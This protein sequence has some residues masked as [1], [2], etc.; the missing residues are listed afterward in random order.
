M[1]SYQKAFIR[2]LGGDEE[3]P[4]TEHMEKLEQWAQA[5]KEIKGQ[6]L[7]PD[8]TA[9]GLK[10][11]LYLKTGIEYPIPKC[12]DKSRILAYY[13]I[14][15]YNIEFCEKKFSSEQDIVL[16]SQLRGLWIVNA[17]PGTGK[18]TVANERAYR[19]REAGVLLISYT[20][21]AINENYKRL[22]EY[23]GLRG[24][25]GKKDYS[26]NINV[27]TADSLASK[28]MG[29]IDNH[30]KT[31]R[32]AIIRIRLKK[33]PRNLEKIVGKRLHVIVDECQDIDDIRGELIMSYFRTMNC[34]SL[35]LF[36]DP[37]QRLNSNAGEWYRKLWEYGQQCV[38]FTLSYRFINPGM[39]ELVNSISSRREQIHH[40][41]EMVD[42]ST[43]RSVPIT[44][45]GS[46]MEDHQIQLTASY[47]KDLLESGVKHS[48]IVVIGPS[49]VKENKTSM[50]ASRI[51]AV[52]N[53]QGIP[54]YTS[55]GGSFQPSGVLFSTIHSVKGKE[56]DYVFIFGMSGYPGTF[57][58]IPYDVAESLIFVSHSRARKQ[59]F[60]IGSHAQFVI[61]RGIAEK[62]IAPSEY[63]VTTN[64]IIEEPKETSLKIS[65]ICLDHGLSRLLKTNGY[66]LYLEDLPQ[67]E[68]MLPSR[69]ADITPRFWGVVC[70][71]GVGIC[72]SGALPQM[73]VDFARNKYVVVTKR[74]YDKMEK[75]GKLRNGFH[76]VDA[77][78]YLREGLINEP[79][80]TEIAE[81]RLLVDKDYLSLTFQELALV[82]MIYD[83]LI[84]NHMNSRYEVS[85]CDMNMDHFD[86]LAK[87]IV[88]RFGSGTTERFV[89]RHGIVGAIDS[90]HDDHV[91][92][93]KTKDDD[94]VQSDLL[95]TMLYCLVLE[96]PEG[97]DKIPVV[98]NLMSGKVCRVL[99]NRSK[100]CWRYIIE[101]YVQLRRQ[102][103]LVQHRVTKA[104]LRG[105][106]VP[107]VIPADVYAVDTEFHSN[108]EIF[109]V[110]L[111][112]IKDPYSSIIQTLITGKIDEAVLWLGQPRELF[113]TSL[114]IEDIKMML[115]DMSGDKI[116]TLLYY[117]CPVDVSWCSFSRNVNLSVAA[118][119]YA[120]KIGYFIAQNGSP[121]KLGDLYGCACSPLEFSCHLKVHTALSDA[122]ILYELL[123]CGI[124]AIPWGI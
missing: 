66:L 35:V 75:E 31:V 16:D 46:S 70:G 82:A 23:P 26:K 63:N 76:V 44:I 101:S 43:D 110:A 17:G 22:H 28:I 64:S 90:L 52:F 55:A 47:I 83:F 115:R 58:M 78:F 62:Y 80:E 9:G 122:L 89:R 4:T 36:G 59:I 81:L 71:V 50:M 3:S 118:R 38:G 10:K 15:G 34:M 39:L 42:R 98:I 12:S 54:C 84:G 25:L 7:Y 109:D 20:N 97:E 57:S 53:Y 114:T 120:S 37:R 33:S 113:Q 32:D 51:C 108:R 6:N 56:F 124:I 69:P 100:Y 45:F 65:E 21:E 18:T 116:P 86:H 13:S 14:K 1:Y 87:Q 119:E 27:T 95:Q 85:H 117:L 94:F 40:N 91:L 77:I 48:E 107:P 88:D 96:G 2:S 5:V 105:K 111:I 103:E 72:L 49:L 8:Y 67:L 11:M 112:N 19:L 104:I 73:C 41:L 60:Y 106:V 79:T 92:E 30:D 123:L 29:Q 24:M 93:F 61:P 102:T 68:S 74:K 99:S 121:P